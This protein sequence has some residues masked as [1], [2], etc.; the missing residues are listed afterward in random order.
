MDNV[1][2][3]PFSALVVDASQRRVIDQLYCDAE[4]QCFK[5]KQPGHKASSCKA[6]T[7]G[8][9]GGVK[10]KRDCDDSVC[11]EDAGPDA[12]CRRVQ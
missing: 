5:C 7:K 10:R 8:G 6:G 2:G 9:C 1:R 3:G 12:K 11:D 4:D